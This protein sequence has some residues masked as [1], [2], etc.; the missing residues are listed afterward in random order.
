[1]VGVHHGHAARQVFHLLA[2]HGL[3]NRID[4]GGA[5]LFD[6]LDPH[7][8]ANVVRF[9]RIVGDALYRP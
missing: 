7:V 5:G 9:H 1:M 2:V 4:I 6:G 3:A 8:E